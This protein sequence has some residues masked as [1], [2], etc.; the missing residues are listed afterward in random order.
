M[1]SIA[2][3][4]STESNNLRVYLFGVLNSTVS[5]KITWNGSNPEVVCSRIHQ[6]LIHF[7]TD[8]QH[9]ILNTQ[10]RYHLQLFLRVYLHKS[11]IHFLQ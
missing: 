3:V 1:Y 6:P 8:A 9:V 11:A 10:G 5:S 4:F 7:I 2:S